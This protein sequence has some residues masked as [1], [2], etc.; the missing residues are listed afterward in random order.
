MPARR[1]GA[2]AKLPPPPALSGDTIASD[3]LRFRG[4]PYVFGAWDCSGFVN[5]VLGQDLGMTLP[6][7]LKGYKGPPPHGP[8]VLDYASWGGAVTVQSPARGDLALW[9]GAGAGGHMGIVL[10]AN[11]MISALN[12][13]MG[14]AVTAIAGFGPPGIQVVYRRVTAAASGSAVGGAGAGG[15]GG[16]GDALAGPAMALLIVAVMAGAV[17]GGAV[18]LGIG[19][20]LL[21]ELALS[22]AGQR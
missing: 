21:G 5:H 12:P 16:V 20:V 3:A 4:H 15:T 7:G 1:G 2:P 18:L 19:A 11:Q 13:A 14:T 22:K 17:I 10:A 8:V 9:P 6:G